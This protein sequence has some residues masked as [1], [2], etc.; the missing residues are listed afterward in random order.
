MEKVSLV[1]SNVLNSQ[2]ECMVNKAYYTYEDPD[3]DVDHDNNKQ[4]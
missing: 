2:P 3:L 4:E 1:E